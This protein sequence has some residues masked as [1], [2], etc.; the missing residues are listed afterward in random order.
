MVMPLV[1]LRRDGDY[2]AGGSALLGLTCVYEVQSLVT[3]ERGGDL[4]AYNCI[5]LFISAA[6][7]A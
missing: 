3:I 6:G 1:V 7:V 4:F 2:A 5:I